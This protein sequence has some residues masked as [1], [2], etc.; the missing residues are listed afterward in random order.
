MIFRKTVLRSLLSLMLLIMCS[1][2]LYAQ[3]ELTQS[4]LRVNLSKDKTSYAGFTMIN[5]VW[6]RYIQN[7]PDKSGFTEP[8]DFDI[9]IRRSRLIFY[10]NL[11]DKVLIYTQVG[12]DGLTY[13]Q[14]DKQQISLINAQT[15]FTL[16]KDLIYIGFGLHTWNGISRY[17]N[18]SATGLLVVDNPGFTYPI[19]GLWDRFGRQMGIYAKGTLGR[20]HYRVSLTKPYK[21]GVDSLTKPVTTERLNDKWATKGYFSWQ[22]LDKENF[23]THS[24]SM[25]NM[26]RSRIFNLGVGFYYH[27]EAMLST[28]NTNDQTTS[29]I[30][31]FATD[32]FIDLPTKNGG[33][34]TSY[35]GYYNY[36]FGK[37]YLR[38]TGR[39][40][41]STAKKELAISQGTGN[42]EWEVGTG[43]MVRAELGY[44]LPNKILNSRIQPFSAMTYK[45]FEALDQ[46]STQFDIGFNLLQMEHN[47]KWTFQG[48]SRP[49]YNLKNGRNVIADTKWQFIVQTQIYF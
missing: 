7:N 46:A 47:I 37:D 35:L 13:N 26:G 45:N 23:S 9:G 21:T 34:L 31:L 25:N 14:P 4:K 41:V 17:N 32:M 2:S 38:S 20:M 42:S 3:S 22:F 28:T 6:T 15:E 16:K 8:N 40:N 33:A 43:T 44:L 18:S 10:T 5:Q 24:M 19:V 27:P 48:S 49:I 12:T 11:M 39:M 30:F 36:D 29:D 1:I